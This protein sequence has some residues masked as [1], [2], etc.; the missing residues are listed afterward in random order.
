MLAANRT[1]NYGSSVPWISNAIIRW[2]I[3]TKLAIKNRDMA[4]AR[5]VQV[6]PETNE[7]SVQF[8]VHDEDLVNYL[9]EFDESEQADETEQAFRVGAMIS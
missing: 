9:A 3:L 4:T 7:V 6:N 2:Q 1:K 5:D 8:T